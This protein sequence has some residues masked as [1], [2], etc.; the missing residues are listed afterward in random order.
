MK[1]LEDLH[2]MKDVTILSFDDMEHV[3]QNLDHLL[4]SMNELYEIENQKILQSRIEDIKCCLQ[5]LR[6]QF[7]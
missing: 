5:D 4:D 1:S 7:D 2:M 3:R 6:R